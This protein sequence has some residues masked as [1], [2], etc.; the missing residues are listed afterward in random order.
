MTLTARTIA[1]FV[2]CSVA[3]L[4]PISYE[5]FRPGSTRHSAPVG[6]HAPLSSLDHKR[7]GLLFRSTVPDASFGKIAYTTIESPQS[8]EVSEVACDR[9]YFQHGR[10]VCQVLDALRFPPY[11]VFVFD[12]QLRPSVARALSGVPNRARVSPDGRRAAITVFE[13]GHSYAEGA[14]STRTTILDAATGELLGDLEQFDI[15]RNGAPFKAVDFNFWGVTFADDGNRFFATLRT[16]GVNYLIEGNVDRK[17]GHVVHTGVECPSLSPD[18]RR[19]AFKKRVTDGTTVL[20]KVAI[21]ELETMTEAVLES[22][23]RSVDDQVDWLDD[24]H[25]VYHLPTKDG[26]DIWS[27]AIDGRDRPRVLVKGGYSPS[28]LR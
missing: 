1:F 17:A 19:I 11:A 15:T 10:G 6:S 5:W 22:E 26:A 12:A 27:L 14:F 7:S 24:R 2:V 4:L 28:V 3:L 21:L 8:W 20:W 25:I 13:S 18:G 23:A 9:V 16:D